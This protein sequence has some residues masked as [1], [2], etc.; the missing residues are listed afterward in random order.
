[1]G[2]RRPS[3]DPRLGR[4][5]GNRPRRAHL[6]A[7]RLPR[8]RLHVLEQL[9]VRRPLQLRHLQPP[10]LPA[11]GGARDPAARRRD[12]LDGD[13]RVRRPRLARVGRARW[14]GRTFAI[15][16]AGIVLS[17][18]FPFALGAALALL[19]LWALQARRP[20]RFAGLAALTAAAS[21]LA[22][23][24]L[25]LIV[26]GVAIGRRAQRWLQAAAGAALL[27]VILLEALLLR[28]FPAT[29]RYPF[30]AAELAAVCVYCLLSTLF[31]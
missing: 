23:L 30:S 27:V 18:A 3:G 1:R 19:A 31:T 7:R 25:A 5:A 2:R 10:L 20:W 26:V 13:A 12:G 11:G 17:A 16:W 15:V 21:P 4:P 6:P 24:L 9:L 28:V 29:G 8:P 14:S 22:F